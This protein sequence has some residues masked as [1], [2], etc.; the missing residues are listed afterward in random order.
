MYTHHCPDGLSQAC[1][2]QR[3]THL[4]IGA[5]P[6]DLEF[7]AMHGI[8]HC[9]QKKDA[10]FSGIVCTDGRGSLRPKEKKGLSASEWIALREAE[11]I[12]A[13]EKG[14]YSFVQLL[15]FQSRSLDTSDAY[16][17]LVNLL[18]ERIE[19]CQPRILYTHSPFDR[20]P[21]HRSVFQATLEAIRSSAQ[22]SSLEKAYGCELWGSLDWLPEPQKI[23]LDHSDSLALAQALYN[24]YPSQIQGGKNYAQALQGRHKANATFRGHKRA[25]SARALSFAVDLSELIE[26]PDLPLAHYYKKQVHRFE[27]SLLDPLTSCETAEKR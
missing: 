10:W 18:R 8:A 27:Q 21:T 20:H 14:G 4:A 5:H 3:T 19:Q 23:G 15:R 6:D 24:C 26:D 7:M 2:F 22:L 16:Q 11:Q 17:A 13:C 12:D 9:Y 25:D 1:A